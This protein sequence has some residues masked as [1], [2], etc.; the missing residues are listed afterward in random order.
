M[1]VTGC[2][3]LVLDLGV[4]LGLELLLV[5]GLPQHTSNDNLQPLTSNRYPSLV[6]PQ[7]H[8]TSWRH[9]DSARQLE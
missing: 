2:W 7:G 1:L 3:L 5:L 4:G 9:E 6:A 8:A